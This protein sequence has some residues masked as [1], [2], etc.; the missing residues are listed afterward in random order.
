M[1]RTTLIIIGICVFSIIL[2]GCQKD[3]YKRINESVSF[4]A[5]VNLK[6][7]SLSFQDAM[8]GENLATWNLKRPITGALLL[9]DKDTL[10][11][12]GKQMKTV[13]VFSLSKGALI[14]S[15]NVGEGIVQIVQLKTS[16]ELALV[17]QVKDQIRFFT[18]K[19]KEQ[20]KVKTGKSPISLVESEKREQLFVLNFHDTKVSIINSKTYRA[21]DGITVNSSSSGILLN[22]N[23][24]ELWVG[25]HGLGSNVED[26]VHVYSID[27][28][29]LIKSINAPT[30][31][32]FL[33]DTKNG[34]FIVSHGSSSIYRWSQNKLESIQVGVNP[35]YL[36]E[37]KGNL[38]VAG[39]DSNDISILDPNTMRILKTVKVG[40]GPFHLFARE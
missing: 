4:Y 15:W 3:N 25:G 19:G 14:D 16:N 40:N 24:S 31:P 20:R 9:D 11:V 6:D 2:S 30:M 23:D 13:D 34:T 27:T 21:E 32:I 10:L 12:Y 1:N 29:K 17:D 37:F 7:G 5:S 35:F 28:G 36:L 26:N 22:E 38:L 18:N 33:K 8:S 39:Y